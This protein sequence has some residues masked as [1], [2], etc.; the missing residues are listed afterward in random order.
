MFVCWD[1]G[2]SLYSVPEASSKV[3]TR[4]F[5]D[6][7]ITTCFIVP[8]IA[9][10]MNKM[11][12]LGANIFPNLRY[13]VFCGESLSAET[14]RQWQAAAPN[15]VVENLYG[16]TE[17]TVAITN[18]KWTDKSFE[19][20]YN[21]VVPIG[22]IFDGQKSCIINENLQ[23][24]QNED[25]ELCISGSQVTTSYFNNPE[26]T[27]SQYIKIGDD[28]W[29]R[30]GDLVRID[31]RGCMYYIGR[32]DNQVKIMGYRVEL[33]EIDCIIK[34]IVNSDMVISVCCCGKGDI[35]NSIVSFVCCEKFIKEREI[36]SFCKT[37]LPDYMM[38]RKIYFIDEMPLN[39]NG[40]IDVVKLKQIVLI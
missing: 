2:S 21:G 11:K 37:K 13:C 1:N 39:N 8:S 30:T 20:C 15:S 19:E 31:Q 14:A 35:G 12:S 36:L 27:D 10:F 3:P 5:I 28:M 25:G 26:K 23:T 16:P 4:F 29:Y 33:Q 18:Y 22:W 6:N 40:K 9:V 7:K 32:I 24:V 38:P 17:A 34:K